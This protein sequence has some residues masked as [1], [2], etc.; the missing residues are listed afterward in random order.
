MIVK[1]SMST[2]TSKQDM[3]FLQ[4]FS[5]SFVTFLFLLPLFVL[6]FLIYSK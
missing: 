6:Y 2:F 4:N 1:P 5:S 3:A